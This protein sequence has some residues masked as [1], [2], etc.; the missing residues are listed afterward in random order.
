MLSVVT[1]SSKQ[2]RYE[3]STNVRANTHTHTHVQAHLRAL[4]MLAMYH[5]IVTPAPG[6]PYDSLP[7]KTRRTYAPD[8]AAARADSRGPA[9]RGRHPCLGPFNAAAIRGTCRCPRRRF[10]TGALQLPRPDRAAAK[11]VHFP[12]LWQSVCRVSRSDTAAWRC[13]ADAGVPQGHAA[14]PTNVGGD[15]RRHAR[16]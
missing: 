14:V 7:V 13:V 6:A 10:G 12:L 5:K 8:G 3:I 11:P 15:T 1:H 16:A 9:V 4:Y 2:S